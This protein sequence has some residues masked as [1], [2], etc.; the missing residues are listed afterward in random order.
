MAD[1][2]RKPTP[3]ESMLRIY[4][5]VTMVL[6]TIALLAWIARAV[7]RVSLS[8]GGGVI[9]IYPVLTSV[10]GVVLQTVSLMCRSKLDSVVS[11]AG[12]FSAVTLFLYMT[13]VLLRHG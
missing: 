8:L 13:N 7:F 6:T 2:T 9:L 10:V 11:V 3:G 12:G 4:A 5:T 1:R